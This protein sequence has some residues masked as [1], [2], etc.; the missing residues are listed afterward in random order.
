MPS[1]IETL[2]VDGEFRKVLG[3]PTQWAPGEK[4]RAKELIKQGV[5]Y[6]TIALALNKSDGQIRAIKSWMTMRGEK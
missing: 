5:P 1:E 3:S 6:E 4:Q 2:M